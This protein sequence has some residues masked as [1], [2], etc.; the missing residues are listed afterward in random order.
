[1]NINSDSWLAVQ[2]LMNLEEE[3][4]VLDNKTQEDEACEQGLCL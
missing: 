3:A 1:M 4:I 2:A